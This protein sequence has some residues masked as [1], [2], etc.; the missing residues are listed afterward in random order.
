MS[1]HNTAAWLRFRLAHNTFT[2]VRIEC[3]ICG[4]RPMFPCLSRGCARK[5]TAERIEVLFG[6]ETLRG[7]NTFCHMGSRSPTKRRERGGNSIQQS[8]DYFFIFFVPEVSYLVKHVCRR[9]QIINR[10][11]TVSATKWRL[12]TDCDSN[13]A[14]K[15][16]ATGCLRTALN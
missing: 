9:Y 4:L 12:C 15:K 10:I 5:K 14:W 11:G 3:I 1:Q 7:Q 8:P 16:S 2:S 6:T 13:N